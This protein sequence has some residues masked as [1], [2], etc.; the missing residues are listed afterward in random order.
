[1]YAVAG[2]GVF[3]AKLFQVVLGAASCV[4]LY[5][6]GRRLFSDTVGVLAGAMLAL[7]AP[8][9]YYHGLLLPATVIVF[10]HLLL[11]YVLTGLLVVWRAAV[12]GGIV[13]LAILAKANAVLLVPALAVVLWFVQGSGVDLRRR[14][15]APVTFAVAAGVVLVPITVANHRLT[16]EVILVTTTGG[17]N[18]MKG[19]GPT[20]TGSHAFLP[21]DAQATGIRAHLDGNV[22]GPSAVAQSR[23]LSD[24]A[25]AYMLEH[26]GRTIALFARKLVLLLNREELGIRDQYYFVSSRSPVLSWPLLSFAIVVPLGLA[27]AVFGWRRDRAAVYAVLAVQ[28]AS[29]MLIFVLAR[30]RLVMVAA[31]MPFAAQLLV[32]LVALA[33]RRD[34]IEAAPRCVALA[35]AAALVFLPIQ[36]FPRDRGWADQYRFLGESL[37]A[38]GELD[39]AAEAFEAARA[40]SWVDERLAP[41][42]R[43]GAVLGLAETRIAQGRADEGRRLL[44]AAMPDVQAAPERFRVDLE[45]RAQTLRERLSE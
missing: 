27:G 6:I 32:D 36:G 22:H 19:N 16:G 30:Y 31:L 20:A 4:L 35:I 28:I 18:L 37:L 39:A 17:S 34:W 45:R 5:G 14:W 40:A 9:I 13:G 3:A 15:A 38:R 41:I 2:P 11:L 12:A 43:T 10:L 1:V 42:H 25:K 21:P 33:R 29:F 8:H 44:D 26:P 23:A 7:Y 24:R